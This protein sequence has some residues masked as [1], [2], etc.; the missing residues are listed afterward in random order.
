MVLRYQLPPGHSHPMTDVIGELE[1]VDP[2][3]IVRAADGS[4]VRC[5]RSG[6]SR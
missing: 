2:V 3:V 4:V 1:C 5:V 6:W